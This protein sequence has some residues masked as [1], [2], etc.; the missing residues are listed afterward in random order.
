MARVL[1][2]G[3]PV[4]VRGVAISRRISLKAWIATYLVNAARHGTGRQQEDLVV[5]PEEEGD[6]VQGEKTVVE[7]GVAVLV[8]RV[9]MMRATCSC[10]AGRERPRRNWTRR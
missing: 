5:V 7:E 3:A 4:P 2:V 6:L 10:K 9:R 8:G 1:V